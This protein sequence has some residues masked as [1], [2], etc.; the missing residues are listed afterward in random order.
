MSFPNGNIDIDTIE[1][2]QLLS[3]LQMSRPCLG[4]QSDNTFMGTYI[5]GYIVSTATK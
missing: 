4:S 1:I 5:M 2:C 3:S